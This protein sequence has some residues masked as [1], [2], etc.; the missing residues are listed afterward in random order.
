MAVVNRGQKDIDGRKSIHAA[1]ESEKGFFETHPAYKSKADFCGTPYLAKRLNSILINHIRNTLPEIKRAITTS[2]QK[3]ENELGILGE[4]SEIGQ[5]TVLS[6]ITEFCNDFRG[7]LDGESSSFMITEL[8]GGARI[9]FVFHEI[10]AS[11]ISSMDPYDQIKDVDVRTLLYN[12]SGSSP[13]LFV[14]SSGLRSLIKSQVKRLDEPSIK[15][16]SLV[17]EELVRILVQLLQKPVMI[18]LSQLLIDI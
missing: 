12:S 13:S 6:I 15:C 1:L 10:F 3:Y 18:F 16:I 14:N 4:S 17:Y 2:I 11:A 8:D 5:S 9:G 7:V